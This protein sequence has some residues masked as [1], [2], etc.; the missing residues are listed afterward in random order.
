[1]KEELAKL[2]G[3]K[4]YFR[5]VSHTNIPDLKWQLVAAYV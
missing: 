5:S 4:Y 3:C 2:V 1:M